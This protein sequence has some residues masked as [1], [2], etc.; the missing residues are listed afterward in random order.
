MKIRLVLIA[1]VVGFSLLSVISLPATAAEPAGPPPPPTAPMPVMPPAS[2]AVNPSEVAVTVNG[3]K[4][5]EGQVETAI[6]PH[7]RRYTASGQ[8][9]PGMLAQLKREARPKALDQLITEKLLEAEI[10]KVDIKV[11]EQDVIDH[12]T[13]IAERQRRPMSL[14]DFK[15]RLA[16]MGQD[17]EEIKKQLLGSDGIKY[18]KLID[19]KIAGK[20]KVTDKDIEKYYNDNKKKFEHP[21]LCRASHIL[22]SPDKTEAATDPNG[23]KAKAKAKAEKLLKELKGGNADFAAIAK[24]NSSDTFSAT[25]GGDLG[26]F[27]KGVMVPPF[28]K[29]A[30]SMKPGEISDVVE[31]QYGFHIIKVAERKDAGTTPLEEAKEEIRQ[32]LLQE[33]QKKY[34]DEYFKSLK[35]KAN[36]VYPPGKKP[37]PTPMMGFPK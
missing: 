26:F 19:S 33:Q 15:K 24:A 23:A 25:K 20:V 12:L 13:E 11:T 1:F 7:L 9:P 37:K 14:E 17:F 5:T 35:A 28:D 36:I 8:L 3:I 31:T 21:E 6:A 16:A 10:K 30:F 4:I 27:K 18:K 22:I 32:I 2:P 29:A 34:S